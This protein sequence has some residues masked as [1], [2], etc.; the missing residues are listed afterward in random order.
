MLPITWSKCAVGKTLILFAV[1]LVTSGVTW[2]VAKKKYQA[3]M[4]QQVE[5][6]RDYYRERNTT[7][8]L[9]KEADEAI[10]KLVEAH[11]EVLHEKTAEARQ[12]AKDL[13]EEYGSRQ[14][15]SQ[16][17]RVTV[18]SIPKNPATKKIFTISEEEFYEEQSDEQ[19]KES[20]T[21]YEVDDVLVDGFDEP[22]DEYAHILGTDFLTEFKKAKRGGHESVFVRNLVLRTDYE[23]ILSRKSYSQS[24]LGVVIPERE[25]K[26][27]MK[28]RQDD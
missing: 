12:V 10:D 13:L 18:P 17:A 20:A 26:R 4:D 28:F 6:I 7:V 23:V 24:V 22:Y 25:R 27:P 9:S 15:T 11:V 16:E 1:T 3:E 19:E 2:E 5:E 21:Y 8:K 14:A